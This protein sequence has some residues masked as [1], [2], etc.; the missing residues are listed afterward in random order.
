MTEEMKPSELGETRD[1]K[2]FLRGW[3]KGLMDG[4]SEIDE[5]TASKL[6]RKCGEA[7][8][9]S[10]VEM[11]GWENEKFDLDTLVSKVDAM[12]DS[13][14]R[15]EGD[16]V[17]EEIAKCVCPLVTWGVIEPNKK[18]CMGCCKNWYKT[19]FR[20]LTGLTEERFE[21]I[22]SIGLGGDKC[23]FRHHLKTE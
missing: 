20:E 11:V 18:M 10:W 16:T 12:P 5:E 6:F 14:W 21:L 17:Y 22:D 19:L 7:C 9:R 13:H 23:V 4:L 15:R 1:E 2:A 3:V 8:L